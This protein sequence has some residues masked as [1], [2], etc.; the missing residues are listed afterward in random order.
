MFV[1]LCEKERERGSRGGEKKRDG[2]RV[3]LLITHSSA[4]VEW[5]FFFSC[6]ATKTSTLVIKRIFLWKCHC[7]LK[8]KTH[9]WVY[10][11]VTTFARFTRS[12]S[13]CET[14][15]SSLAYTGE[16]PPPK[17]KINKQVIHHPIKC[18]NEPKSKK[19]HLAVAVKE[20]SKTK[21]QSKVKYSTISENPAYSPH[22]LALFLT[23][24]ECLT[25]TVRS[26]HR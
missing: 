12:A 18:Q 23:H 1:W 3:C 9:E 24:V 26:I 22:T 2:A 25:Q 19:P 7:A 15:H 11:I 8:N 14:A 5:L 6:Y 20:Q 4:G 10:C 13:A 16:I 21:Q 17:K